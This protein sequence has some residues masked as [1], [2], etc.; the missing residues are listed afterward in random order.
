MISRRNFLKTLAA[1][2]TVLP[3]SKAFAS[4]KTERIFNAYNIHTGESLN[5]KYF[6]SGIYDTNA[7]ND[8]HHLLRCHHTNQV[9]PVDIELLN[10][11]SDIRN[12]LGKDKLIHVISGY[13]SS[14]YNEHLR[15]LG[16]KVAKNSLHLQ[17]LAIDLSIPGVDNY[18]LYRIAKS[19]GLGGV[20]HYPEFVH[21]DTG[22]IRYW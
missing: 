22:R 19:F 17:G 15:S 3:F 2:M 7:L 4:Q 20:G 12:I 13:R 21:I 11:F 5:I 14:A 18:E 1:G 16:R 6:A 10:L 8:I 9:K